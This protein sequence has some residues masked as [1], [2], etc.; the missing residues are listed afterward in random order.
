MRFGLETTVGQDSGKKLTFERMG[1]SNNTVVR[2]DG[3]E[4]IFGDSP[5]RRDGREPPSDPRFRGHWEP[6]MM[7]DT[8]L[9]KDATGRTREGARSVWVYDRE[10]VYVTQTVELVPGEQSRLIDTCLVRYRLENRD[11]KPHRVGLRF[12]LDTYIGGNDGVP[13]TIPGDKELCNTMHDFPDPK[14]VPD[15]IQAL[16]RGDLRDP[17]TICHLQLRLGGKI[18]APDRVTLGAWPNPQLRSR[19]ERCMQE[20]TLWT[21]PVF[22]M[23]TLDPPDSAVTMYWN[24]RPLGP[25]ESREVGFAYGLGNVAS[26]EGGGKL[27]LTVG[28]L[29]VPGGEFT[30]TAYVSNP[31]PGQTLTLTLPEGFRLVE[32]EPKKEVP[33]LPPQSASPNSPVTWRIRA[34]SREGQ[35]P[36]KVQSSTGV[37][38]T[39]TVR[40]RG[41]RL[42]D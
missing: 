22:S 4:Y 38:Q 2:L 40:I 12:L 18:D 42:F 24:D 25:G 37:A 3:H 13:F 21:V 41:N 10:K 11:D 26:G 16:E 33:P 14:D 5:F 23:Q 30:L 6:G 17:G 32:G 29:F 15:F 20:K 36:L 31:Q 7:K 28:G 34:G 39:T 19:D 8:N 1:G 9:G 35:F 27:A